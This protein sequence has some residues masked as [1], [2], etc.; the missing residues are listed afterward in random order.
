LSLLCQCLNATLSFK[1]AFPKGKILKS[2]FNNKHVHLT[3]P[4]I[5]LS[6]TKLT[7]LFNSKQSKRFNKYFKRCFLENKVMKYTVTRKCKDF[8]DIKI[9]GEKCFTQ[10]FTIIVF[11]I[12]LYQ[13]NNCVIKY[14]LIFHLLKQKKTFINW[15]E[16]RVTRQIKFPDAHFLN[17]YEMF[18]L[19]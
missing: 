8:A 13:S 18:S 4:T 7:L 17:I 2:F 9:K 19:V 5:L 1:G 6:S 16:Q 11:F 15:E 3:K 10:L 12:F 14:K